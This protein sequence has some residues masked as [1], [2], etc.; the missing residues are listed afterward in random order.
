MN[1]VVK[2]YD[3]DCEICKEMERHDSAVFAEFPDATY[4]KVE[5]NDLLDNGR[6]A[7]KQV[8][9]RC[10]EAHCLNPD[11]TIDLPIYLFLTNKGEYLGSHI[12]AATI[13]ELR[14]RVKTLLATNSVNSSE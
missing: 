6:D 5:L 8:I 9:Y 4:R 12:G 3:H 10:L 1:L 11:Y 14:E 7:T 13:T 2:I